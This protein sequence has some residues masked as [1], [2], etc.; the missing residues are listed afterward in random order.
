MSLPSV[1]FPSCF[2]WHTQLLPR[3]RKVNE[4]AKAGIWNVG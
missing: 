4:E 1:D 3:A 2:Y